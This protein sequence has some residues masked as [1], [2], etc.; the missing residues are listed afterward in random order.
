MGTPSDSQALVPTE[1]RDLAAA[2]MEELP[3]MRYFLSKRNGRTTRGHCA[4]GICECFP[5]FR[6]SLCELEDPP[7]VSQ[8]LRAAIHYITAETER[9]LTDI[10]R[11]L[12]SLWSRFN[13]WHDYPIIV[14]HEGL[15]EEALRRIIY[16]SENR[17]WF[18]LLAS[19][20][21]VPPEWAASSRESA[22]E[23]S[24]GYRAMIRW[25][26]GPMFLEPALADFDYAMTLDTDS[27][28]PAELAADPFMELHKRNLVAGFPHLGRESA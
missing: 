13:R 7:R 6:G 25:R 16:A 20:K 18:V 9:D 24:V 26:S 8:T 14:F 12:A 2:V 1:L 4:G 10:V 3:T 28:L 17:V 23:F 21:E 19:F 27:Y 5:P 15:S 22:Q 11:S